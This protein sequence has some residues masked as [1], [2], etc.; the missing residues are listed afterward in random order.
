M[1]NKKSPQSNK[2]IIQFK[3]KRN[4]NSKS[5]VTMLFINDSDSR[6]EK[7]VN[8]SER[9]VKNFASTKNS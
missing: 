9:K 7:S 3:E 4:S 1:K 6:I 5:R 2:K 8:V